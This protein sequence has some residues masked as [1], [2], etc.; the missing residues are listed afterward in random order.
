MPIVAGLGQEIYESID[1][2]FAVD[3]DKLQAAKPLLQD[4]L[5]L[6]P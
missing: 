4:F 2:K 3:T 1:F 6:D 5:Q